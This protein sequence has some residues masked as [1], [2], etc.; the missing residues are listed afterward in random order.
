M[1]VRL[2]IELPLL[3]RELIEL[4][5]RRRT[6]LLRSL[7]AIL[8]LS[9]V[10]YGQY[11]LLPGT[12]V[13]TGPAT[14]LGLTPAPLRVLGS[15][16]LLFAGLIPALLLVIPMLMPAM[17]AAAIAAEKE[18]NT[19]GTL[20]LTRL[21][22][23]AIILEKLFSR[24][25]PMMT[26]LLLVSP[27][28]AYLYSLGGVDS[29]LLFGAILLL[30]CEC[31][32]FASMSL[33]LSAWF[34]ST[35]ATFVWSYIGSAA[36]LAFAVMA[37]HLPVTGFGIWIHA[38]TL[39]S[40]ARNVPGMVASSPMEQFLDLARLAVRPIV[41]AGLFLLATRVV[42]VRRAFVGHSSLLIGMFR[43]ID[44]FFRW[45]NDR[46]TG[47]IN[48]VEESST[49][50]NDDPVTWRERNKKS[51]GQFRWLVRVLLV[52]E[53]PTIFVCF[54]VVTM[55]LTLSGSVTGTMLLLLWIFA[56]VLAA[57]K[58]SSLFSQERA[59]Q[60]LEPLLSTSLTSRELVEQKVIG[61]NR[62]LMVLAMP[63]IT[64]YF[65]EAFITWRSDPLNKLLYLALHLVLL[66]TILRTFVWV[67]A[68][69]GMWV[70]S[71]TRAVT[72][73]IIFNV[74]FVV[75]S[76]LPA[77]MTVFFMLK[78]ESSTGGME[79]R[80]AGLSA[81]GAVASVEKAFLTS[82]RPFHYVGVVGRRWNVQ[83]WDVQYV[84][85]TEVVSIGI[86]V[87]VMYLLITRWLVLRLSPRLLQRWDVPPRGA[88]TKGLVT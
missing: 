37:S 5:Q 72:V 47:G 19:F 58:G 73:S 74:L 17:C 53:F 46:T 76:A 9:G 87:Q 29:G 60:T 88:F 28:L 78:S 20:L 30:F 3:R 79:H 7:V 24:V 82:D 6:Y 13:F 41:L 59:R 33:F 25:I 10:V 61:S 27:V 80:L 4:A 81:F 63:I 31:L 83:P 36:L 67:S 14:G 32:L 77:Q 75:L 86:V 64:T 56:G 69:V 44:S 66:F 40:L 50:P 51:L 45:L 35:V 1:A 15:G 55:D 12:P 43:R 65:T 71:S 11:V 2:P 84:S 68:A 18:Q 42:L 52:L 22:P 38:S 62:L 39:P 21:S 8:L 48:V 54:S 49:L 70:R 85:A 57:A 23:S 16:G 26:L 34:P